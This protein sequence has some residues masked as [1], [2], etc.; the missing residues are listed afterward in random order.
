VPASPGLRRL[1]LRRRGQAASGLSGATAGQV[2]VAS[3]ATTITTFSAFTYTDATGVLDVAKSLSGSTVAIQ[4]RNPS[5]TASSQARLLAEVAGA[6]AG[7]PSLRLSVAGVTN[8]DLQVANSPSDALE[9]AVGGA[10]VVTVSTAGFVGIG[11]AA[12]ASYKL[13][14][15]DAG[16][17]LCL[18]ETTSTSSASMWSA[19]AASAIE[20][21]LKAHGSAEGG[22]IFGETKASTV[23]IEA[24]GSL[25][26]LG[27]DGANPIGLV[28][29]SARRLT[30]SGVGNI[31]VG[32]GAIATNATDGFLYIST[33]AGTPTGTPTAISGRAPIHVD[34]TNNK[35]YFYSSGA[36]RDAGP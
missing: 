10:A 27:I 12:D 14:I 33:S 28:T 16:A 11:V 4:V 35:L 1:S 15:R 23:G 2:V 18:T 7:N 5:N 20:A 32:A 17:C 25:L 29:N 26:M 30:I 13:K 24:Y 34:T 3:G 6:T 9:V 22:T 21:Q 36:W 31:S 19:S 8:W